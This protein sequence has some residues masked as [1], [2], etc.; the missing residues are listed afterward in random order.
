[1]SRM[2]D[3]VSSVRIYQQQGASKDEGEEK[4][5]DYT[6]T[7]S[8]ISQGDTRLFTV[9]QSEKLNFPVK[10][11]NHYAKDSY[12][13]LVDINS[14][15]VSDSYFI[16]PEGY[17]EVDDE[18]R[19]IIP[20]PPAPKTWST[21]NVTIP[22]E[23]KV[24][25]GTK[26]KMVIPESVYYKFITTNAGD[27]PTKFT[28]HLYENGEKLSWEIVGN[29]ERRTHRLYMEEKKTQ[30]MDWKKDWEL[31]IEVYEGE[32]MIEVFPE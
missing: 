28:Y 16:V 19:P 1:M 32:V 14:W 22:F 21:K 9:W 24:K 2:N 23:G 29:D 15:E 3:P 17:T 20:E 27:T 6:C 26:I 7:K 25:R 8:S 10:I 4:V 5:G 31:I 13:E 30:T 18:M 11:E 12:M